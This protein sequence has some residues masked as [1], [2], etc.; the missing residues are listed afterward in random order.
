M[1]P[2]KHTQALGHSWCICRVL[3]LLQSNRLNEPYGNCSS[4][5]DP[6]YP[7]EPYTRYRCERRCQTLD[8]E[9][10]CKCKASFMPGDYQYVHLYIYPATSHEQ[11]YDK[12][13]V[14]VILQAVPELVTCKSFLHVLTQ[15]AV[16][17]SLI[18]NVLSSLQLRNSKF[19][20]MFQTCVY[21]VSIK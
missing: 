18:Q 2:P 3:I 17:V 4:Q 19:N 1:F 16:S 10:K 12:W 15:R 8:L 11:H 5:S 14:T 21:S 7:N 9:K 6:Y 13:I 20:V